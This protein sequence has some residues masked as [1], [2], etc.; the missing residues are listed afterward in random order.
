M[1]GSVEGTDLFAEA[2]VVS[3]DVPPLVHELLEHHTRDLTK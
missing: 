1:N 3:K 2:V